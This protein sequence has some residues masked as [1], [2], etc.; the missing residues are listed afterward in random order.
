MTPRLRDALLGEFLGT[1]LLVLFGC[2][3]VAV[4]VLFGGHQSLFQVAIV[5]GIGVALA[6]YCTRHLSGA[7]LNP[8]VT[9]GLA[10][11]GMFPLSRVP[12]YIAVQFAGAC[13]AAGALY[14]LFNPSIEAFEAAHRIVRGTPESIRTAQMFGEFYPNPGAGPHAV[15]S[16]ALAFSAEAFGTFLLMLGILFLT[17]SRNQGFPGKEFTPVMIGLLV[18][19]IICLIAPLTQAGLNPARD[20]APRLVA[21]AAG[22]GD[23]AFPRDPGSF[24]TVYVMAPI[25]GSIVAMRL[26]KVLNPFQE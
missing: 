26:Y 21:A 24:L 8:A 10:S 23:A 11:G 12:L 16:Q 25:F 13:C 14:G 18:T 17:D 15:V 4:A 6:I 20:L 5:W 19:S 7:H 9:M 22:W 2:G 3:S 1:F